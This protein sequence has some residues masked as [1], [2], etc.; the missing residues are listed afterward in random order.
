VS[1][2]PTYRVVALPGDGIGPE[3][4]RSGRDV[5]DVA[6]GIFGFSI[7]WTELVVGGAAIDAYGVAM[8]DEDLAVAEASDAVY[9]GAVGG[10]RWDDPDGTVRPE[11]ALFKLRGG[12]DLYANLRPV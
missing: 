11:Q 5:L 10:P 12:L 7:D 2:Q 6:G 8:R 4:L 9:L 1:D 3:V